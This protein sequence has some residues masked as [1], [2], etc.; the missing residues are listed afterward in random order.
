MQ[1]PAPLLNDLNQNLLTVGLGTFILVCLFMLRIG[2][3]AH[4]FTSRMH[5]KTTAFDLVCS[6]VHDMKTNHLAHIE[7]SSADALAV[8]KE[9]L[10]ATKGLA[11]AITDEFREIRGLVMQVKG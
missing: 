8:A 1:L 5:E 7:Q 10:E 11:K 3:K 4:R 2:W 6:E 9:Q